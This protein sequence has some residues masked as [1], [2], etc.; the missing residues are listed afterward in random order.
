MKFGKRLMREGALHPEVSF[1]AYKVLKKQINS[2]LVGCATLSPAQLSDRRR[3][4]DLQVRRE[5]LNKVLVCCG[6]LTSQIEAQCASLEEKLRE[7]LRRDLASSTSRHG[8]R[9]ASDAPVV[10]STVHGED[11]VDVA[12]PEDDGSE[13]ASAI[14]AE[15][16]QLGLKLA[17]LFEYCMLN[18]TGLRKIVKK[19]DKR[20]VAGS[21]V[22]VDVAKPPAARSNPHADLSD[23]D[24]G[25]TSED[26]DVD[27]EKTS[28][29]PGVVEERPGAFDH[30]LSRE[31]AENIALVWKFTPWDRLVEDVARLHAWFRKHK[32]LTE[33]RQKDFQAATARVAKE[34]AAA[35]TS[36]KSSS[37]LG[38]FP[39]A[40]AAGLG[41]GARLGGAEGTGAPFSHNDGPPRR[42]TASFS[43]F[44]SLQG[45]LSG[46]GKASPSG[47]PGSTPLVAS[48][49]A[50]SLSKSSST[51]GSADLETPLLA[52]FASPASASG[53][54][55]P[56][57]VWKLP[58]ELQI[59]LKLR[60]LKHFQ[61]HRSRSVCE[62]D[63]ILPPRGPTPREDN[64]HQCNNCKL[65][66]RCHQVVRDGEGRGGRMAAATLKDVE[67]G[68]EQE[69]AKSHQRESSQKRTCEKIKAHFQSSD[70]RGGESA[71]SRVPNHDD[72]PASLRLPNPRAQAGAQHTTDHARTTS[73]APATSSSRTSLHL[74][75][76]SDFQATHAAGARRQQTTKRKTSLFVNDT[77]VATVEADAAGLLLRGELDVD[78]W[79]SAKVLLARLTGTGDELTHAAEGERLRE[80]QEAIKGS[81]SR[82]EKSAGLSPLVSD[83]MQVDFLRTHFTLADANDSSSCPGN[84]TEQ[85][86]AKFQYVTVEE[87]AHNERT[88]FRYLHMALLLSVTSVV[89]LRFPGTFLVQTTSTRA[90]AFVLAGLAFFVVVWSYWLFEKRLLLLAA[91]AAPGERP[92]HRWLY[93]ACLDPLGEKKRLKNETQC[94]FGMDLDYSGNVLAVEVGSFAH[95]A[96]LQKADRVERI[97]DEDFREVGGEARKV[98]VVEFVRNG[99]PMETEIVGT[100]MSRTVSAK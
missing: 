62:L 91:G 36:K 92:N 81:I 13:R 38:L 98:L 61:M 47:S 76:A 24:D 46:S 32:R 21:R 63:M 56:G 51:I 74:L 27:H 88:Y 5:V 87:Q 26:V 75:R 93:C 67:K 57:R 23:E 34:G 83:Q 85:L 37:F 30:G 39:G 70:V 45:L 3:Q 41:G 79:L 25:R 96:G 89:L 55:Q 84:R 77:R 17:F 90:C 10:R 53:P 94:V 6:V 64:G 42:S 15:L 80:F 48:S 28:T 1:V 43:S 7:C 20:V 78:E 29:A 54:L 22:R 35:S 72:V 59:Q 11:K 33:Q 82:P 14:E 86:D 69:S 71:S 49:P 97:D 68:G 99:V 2:I 12:H 66:L 8:G 52:N 58:A 19:F 95:E 4:F 9:A 50:G 31:W 40:Q 73:P 16:D 100:L 60:L 44:G 65:S 18:C